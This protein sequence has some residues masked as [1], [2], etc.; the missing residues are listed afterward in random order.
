MGKCR[1]DLKATFVATKKMF[2]SLKITEKVSF[3]IESK[4][5]YVY[6]LNG[7]KFIKNA[8]NGQFWQVF[9]NMKLAVK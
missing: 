1:D 8:K 6:I 7:Q 5:S 3:N 4:A 9:E 2:H